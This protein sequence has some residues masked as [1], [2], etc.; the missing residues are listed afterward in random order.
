MRSGVTLASL[1][2]RDASVQHVREATVQPRLPG[3][4]ITAAVD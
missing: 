2:W 3:H 1:I 4:I